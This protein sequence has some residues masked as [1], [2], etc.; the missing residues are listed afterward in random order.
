M[1]RH[2][3]PCAPP[4]IEVIGE[5]GDYLTAVLSELDHAPSSPAQGQNGD[6]PA[7]AARRT[8]LDRRGESPL[9]VLADAIAAG[10]PVLGGLRRRPARRLDGLRARSGGLRSPA[11]RRS[12][13]SPSSRSDGASW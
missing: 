9:A 4:P 10:G 2:E 6:R 12:S 1:L 3:Q 8:V 13:A 7:A 5:P 11:I